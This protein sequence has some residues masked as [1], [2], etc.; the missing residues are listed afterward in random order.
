MYR[1]AEEAFL[2]TLR[3]NKRH[4]EAHNNLAT[5]YL[6]TGRYELAVKNLK[7]YMV[8]KPF[9]LKKAEVLNTL[10]KFTGKANE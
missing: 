4:A 9:D 7:Q 6:K 2:K 5:L 3:I 1:L 10:Q 8:L